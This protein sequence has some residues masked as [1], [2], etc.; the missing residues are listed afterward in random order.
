MP[1]WYRRLIDVETTSCVY[2]VYPLLCFG[3]CCGLP[4]IHWALC[5]YN[6]DNVNVMI[7]KVLGSSYNVVFINHLNVTI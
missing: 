2:W 3:S 6:F 1:T 7:V 4:L 5:H